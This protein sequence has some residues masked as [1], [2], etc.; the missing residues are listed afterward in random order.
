MGQNPM[1]ARVPGLRRRRHPRTRGTGRRPYRIC[2]HA[3]PHQP[4]AQGRP[5]TH[6]PP[7][8]RP[9]CT[10]GHP[11][12]QHQ[13]QRSSQGHVSAPVAHHALQA[14]GWDQSPNQPWCRHGGHQKAHAFEPTQGHQH[15]TVGRPAARQAAQTQQGH[16]NEH[17]AAKTDA[18]CPQT[19]HHPQSH[20][21]HLHHGQQETR[22]DQRDV[23]LGAQHWQG[24]RQLADVQRHADPHP[25]HP[26]GGPGTRCMADRHASTC[27]PVN[28]TC[29]RAAKR[30]V[31]PAM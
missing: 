16:A 7:Q 22:L 13:G 20:A 11:G 21:R 18:I 8:S 27:W 1:Q 23:Q 2:G 26:P 24:R 4:A 29:S 25:D 15:P 28:R 19:G 3:A 14:I 10:F 30:S 12:S 31:M 9:P 5:Q 6:P 17:T